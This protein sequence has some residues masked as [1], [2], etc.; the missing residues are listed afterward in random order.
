MR[1]RITKQGP[2]YSPFRAGLGISGRRENGSQGVQRRPVPESSYPLRRARGQRRWCDHVRSRRATFRVPRYDPR[3]RVG[4]AG[5]ATDRADAARNVRANRAALGTPV[6]Q[7]ISSAKPPDVLF[8]LDS[9]F[10]ASSRGSASR[11]TRS[12]GQS[13]SSARK[14]HKHSSPSR[15]RG[16]I[17]LP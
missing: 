6:P 15:R 12:S 16:R 2:D 13:M 14:K 4:V 3:S 8:R 17:Q 9:P 11:S 7:M 5:F 10:S 1:Q